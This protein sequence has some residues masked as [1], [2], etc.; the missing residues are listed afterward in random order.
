MNEQ[1]GMR[2]RDSTPAGEDRLGG[3]PAPLLRYR[4]LIDDALR[5]EVEALPVS[6][7]PAVAYHFGW[8]ETD[9]A[10]AEGY[11][12]KAVRPAVTL[13]A[14]EAAGGRPEQALPG[15]V[16]LELVHNFSLIH[17]DIIDRDETRRHRA[18]V[19][20]TWGIAQAV[21]VGDAMLA[22]A[23]RLL[24]EDDVDEGPAA[25]RELA[26][27]TALMIEGQCED[28]TL[29][30]GD[31]AGAERTL[32]MCAHKTGALLG[33]AGALGGLMAGAPG[34][35]VDALREFGLELGIAFQAV[36]DILGIWGDPRKT[37]KPIAGDVRERKKSLPL[38]H[39]LE[40]AEGRRLGRLLAGDL[41][42][43]A[44]AAA[45]EILDEA[46]SREWTIDLARRHLARALASLERAEL[47]PGPVEDL[48]SVSRFLVE[49]EF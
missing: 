4:R 2:D 35:T 38:V 25:A 12:G 48:E 44:V 6:C 39:G 46:G 30:A 41:D 10:A 17:D 32:T 21:I 24:L 31:E 43:E 19:W 13:L 15:A 5:A 33:C 28:M 34:Q 40:S 42:D 27:A 49:R 47:R 36:D 20:A 18:T 8:R 45:V 14:A 11:G 7:M 16:A 22:H 1:G 29:A 37:G 9:G 26:N 23:Q 3:V